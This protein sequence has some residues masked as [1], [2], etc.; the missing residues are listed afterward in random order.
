MK[1]SVFISLVVLSC[2]TSS[3]ILISG[4]ASLA[5]TDADGWTSFIPTPYDT[6]A[7]GLTDLKQPGSRLIYIS[8]NGD[9]STAELYFWDGSRIVDSS[10]KPASSDGI[11]FGND[12]MN[13][14]GPVKPFRR[15]A[16][17]AP[18]RNNEDI[19][20][21]WDGTG[22]LAPGEFRARTRY[23][24][25]D[26]WLFQRGE[27]YDLGQDLLSFA[28]ETDPT[29][30]K[31][32]SG[33]LAVSG[34]RSRSERQVVGAYGSLERPR[35]RFI[36]PPSVFIGRWN[37]PEPKHIAYVS[38]HFDA[39]EAGGIGLQLM[40]QNHEAVDFLVEDCW[41]DGANSAVQNTSVQL[42]FRRTLIT[43]A[44]RDDHRH[45]Q[46][47][48]FSG[49]RDSRLRFEESILMRNG[50]SNGDP[51]EPGNWPPAG[52]Q[53]YDIFNR[54]LYLSGQCDNMNSGVF[55]TLSL[56]GAS[57]DQFRCGMRV[58]RNFFYQG[59]VSM[60]AYGGY[61]SSDGPSGS[62]VDNVLLRFRGSGT[63]DN[64]G[65]PGWGFILSSGAYKVQ[66]ARNIVSG[67]QYPVN[68]YGL[69]VSPL[70]WSCYAHV[71]KYPTRENDTHN[72]IF[73]TAGASAAISIVDGVKPKNEA[74]SGWTYPGLV[75][76]SVRDNVLI[77]SKGSAWI[78]SPF[79][80]ANGT[81][82]DT[83]FLD[84]TIYTSRAE[85]A[86]ALGWPDPDRTLATYMKS[87]GYTVT[88]ADGF[89]EFFAEATQQRK[90]YWRPEFTARGVINYMREG[91]GM[92][93]LDP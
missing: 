62:I 59:Y 27:V 57:G 45:V 7:F 79:P 2:L 23:G 60:G 19:G 6:S 91:F 84:N 93:L 8:P 89:D 29:I 63:N 35:P 26:W 22:H 87:L 53:Y 24:Y 77:N 20:T 80:A 81:T 41:F 72:N 1:K 36:N 76:N 11:P 18:R 4:T 49:K 21:P 75:G 44:H 42:T 37:K 25:P 28:Q 83:S 68:H 33:S 47:L 40:S 17:V 46:G 65:H 86:A 78:Y 70:D 30:K 71:F 69:Q 48:F 58:E 51:S 32:T 43:D 15:W 31:V 85:A 50:F 90:G 61:P 66:I 3:P 16:Y 5:F 38:L 55:D 82:H 73:D 9:D 67:A 52:D 54:N 64:R 39:H 74:C 92:P 34:G 12:P 88:S 10:G 56:L 14:S 13:P